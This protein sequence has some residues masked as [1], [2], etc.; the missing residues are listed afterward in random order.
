MTPAYRNLGDI[1]RK[2]AH[3]NADALALVDPLRDVAFSCAQVDR[4]RRQA[5]MLLR[6]AHGP[7]ARVATVLPICSVAAE[8]VYAAASAAVILV[9]VNERLTAPELAFV[10]ADAE[11][12]AAVT[13]A[14]RLD[15]VRAA[16]QIAGLTAMIY[17]IDG[18]EAGATSYAD[19]VAGAADGEL[20]DQAGHDDVAMLLYT[21]GT[22]G[23]PK[24]V[25]LTHGNF[26]N[27]AANYL[28][29]SFGP[30]EGTYLA[31][32]PYSHIGC[33]VHIA[34]AMRGL[35]LLVTPFAADRVLDL[36][37]RYRVTHVALVPT[38]I[39]MLLDADAAVHDCSSLQR[40]LYA[41]A[42]MPAPLLR[43][44][45]TAFGPI[46]EQFYGLTE[47]TG[48][49]TIL[50][51]A[52]HVTAGEQEGAAASRLS[53]CGKE[54][55]GVW[56]DLVGPDGGPVPAG[57]RGEIVISGPGVM[58]GYWN[59]KAAT[60]AAVRD[61]WLYSADIGCRDAAGYLTI[62]DRL[63]DVIITGGANVYPKEV[64]LVLQM[65]DGV[66]EASVVG[67]PHDVW[68]E[69]VTATVV[70][71]SDRHVPEH[72]LLAAC[73]E[74]LASYKQPRIIRYVSSLPKNAL[75]KVDKAR[76][77]DDIAAAGSQEDGQ[78]HG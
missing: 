14:A 32:V 15:T 77:R 30:G 7:G 38:M 13:T 45:L 29:E 68:G 25:M 44:A 61:G 73:Q 70:C 24:G 4:R 62:V 55:T 50:R 36:V 1:A 9:P 35:R 76:V 75:G 3:G 5:A 47:S 26:L 66:T 41:A 33:V 23:R 65:V 40:I 57:E 59:N 28:M 78:R 72:E 27:S 2:R 21:S 58:A 11:I 16:L 54:V 52:E 53:S 34:A 49:V 69:I 56:T 42:P 74:Q 17:V 71:E 60:D 22:T 67:L 63:K 6:F 64:E 43:R 51:A 46:L 20:P 12:S 48:L 37:E 39:A 18:P 8:I 10:F 31:C 19:A